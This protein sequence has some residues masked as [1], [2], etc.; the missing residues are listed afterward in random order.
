M[1]C[2]ILDDSDVAHPIRER[3]LP[4]GGDLVDLT[5]VTLLQAHLQRPHRRIEPL[6]VT[7][8]SDEMCV[9]ERLGQ[10]LSGLH[11]VRKRLLHEHVHTSG[12][13]LQADR[14]VVLGRHRDG[15]GVDSPGDHLRNGACT[16]DVSRNT[17]DVTSGVADP[18]E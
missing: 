12:G 15:C 10:L 9:I 5:Q 7:H 4:G 14:Q 11:A 16:P 17:V 3:S 1:G 18:H 13:Q 6:D 8:R 2:E